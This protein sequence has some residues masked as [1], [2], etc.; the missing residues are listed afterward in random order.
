MAILIFFQT[1]RL[2][3]QMNLLDIIMEERNRELALEGQRFWDLVRTNRAEEVLGPLGF[4]PNK[5][6][7]LPIPQSEIDI[8]EGRITQN[9]W[10]TSI[11]LI[12]TILRNNKLFNLI[13]IF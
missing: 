9:P 8:S 11:F 2:P 5:N 4:L 3:T 7:L 10:V 1:L 6:E 12:N 13:K